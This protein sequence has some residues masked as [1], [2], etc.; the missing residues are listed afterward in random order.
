MTGPE[1]L[2][3]DCQIFDKTGA[4]TIIKNEF[5]IANHEAGTSV[6]GLLNSL[7]NIQITINH[8][9]AKLAPKNKFEIIYF[10][11][12]FLNNMNKIILSIIIGTTT[13]SVLIILN[14]SAP[15][16]IK[17]LFV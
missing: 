14:I 9:I 10:S 16:P 6:S 7:F 11:K 4:N 2:N 8:I 12:V 13:K 1:G 5:N 3:L 15:V 17:S